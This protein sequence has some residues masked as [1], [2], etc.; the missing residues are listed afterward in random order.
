M[1]TLKQLIKLQCK[2]IL[3]EAA[4]AIKPVAGVHL[5]YAR[6]LNPNPCEAYWVAFNHCDGYFTVRMISWR[7]WGD[8]IGFS[9]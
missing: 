1:N 6:D 8:G 9:R 7:Y 5:L 4:A 3:I 2:D